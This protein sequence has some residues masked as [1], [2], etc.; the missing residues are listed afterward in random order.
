MGDSGVPESDGSSVFPL[1][2]AARLPTGEVVKIDVA[3]FSPCPPPLHAINLPLTRH[4]LSTLLD[5]VTRENA[6]GCT[7]MHWSDWGGNW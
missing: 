1:E 7:L 5:F 4:L 6:R 3:M 2:M